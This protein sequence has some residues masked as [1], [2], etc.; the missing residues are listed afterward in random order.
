MEFRGLRTGPG[1]HRS[2]HR[3]SL[4]LPGLFRAAAAPDVPNR[5][6]PALVRFSR[7]VGSR[8]NS[9]IPPFGFAWRY[10]PE[11][12]AGPP[13]KALRS[14]R[15]ELRLRWSPRKKRSKKENRT[16]TGHKQSRNDHWVLLA[17]R[18]KPAPPATTAPSRL[19]PS[20]Q[21]AVGRTARREPPTNR[22]PLGNK[23]VVFGPQAPF[24]GQ[25][26]LKG[27]HV[28]IEGELRT[29]EYTD[30]AAGA[31]Q[32]DHGNSAYSASP[33]STALRSLS[34][35][36]PPPKRPSLSVRWRLR[37]HSAVR[38]AKVHRVDPRE[39]ARHDR[40]GPS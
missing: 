18:P 37:R 23:C 38:Q 20:P 25:T 2:P 12:R 15:S 35:K 6:K 32:V 33:S 21:S 9:S 19:F 34:A 4:L 10:S 40:N 26:L 1:N 5:R 13:S 28:Q 11:S 39:R 8:R 17:A 14:L 3:G 7:F 22:R 27:A 30:Q 29:R 24:V 16:K 36:G 31:K